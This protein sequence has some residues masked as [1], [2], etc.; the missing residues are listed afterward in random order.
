VGE[1]AK[2]KSVNTEAVKQKSAVLTAQLSWCAYAWNASPEDAAQ[3]VV[4]DLY[5]HL[6]RGGMVPVRIEDSDGGEYV[7]EVTARR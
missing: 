6:S 5:E 3:Q 7:V 4:A 1:P 2:K